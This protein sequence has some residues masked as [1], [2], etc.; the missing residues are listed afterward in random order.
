[1]FLFYS[2]AF[3]ESTDP[4]DKFLG[5][6]GVLELLNDQTA[7]EPSE[8]IAFLRREIGSMAIGNSRH[9]DATLILGHVTST[10]VGLL[11]NLLSPFRLLRNVVDNTRLME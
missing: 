8:L 4:D 2:D 1:M 11:N 9:D 10:S 5:I 6:G 7:L 3:I